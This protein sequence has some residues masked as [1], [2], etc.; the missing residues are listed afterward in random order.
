MDMPASC[1]EPPTRSAASPWPMRQP[2]TRAP[3]WL[4]PYAEDHWKVNKKL[5]VD[6]GLRWDYIPPVH[7]KAIPLSGGQLHLQ[8]PEPKYH[9]SG[10]RFPRRVGVCRELWWCNR[11]HQLRLHHAYPDLLEELGTAAWRCLFHRS[12]KTIVPGRLR[13]H[14]RSGRRHRRRPVKWRRWRCQQLRPDSRLQHQLQVHP[15]P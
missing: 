6:L 11:H 10:H 14:L 2:N 3:S 4:P 12:D 8:L 15:A 1:W 13:P 9:E 7:E 5:V